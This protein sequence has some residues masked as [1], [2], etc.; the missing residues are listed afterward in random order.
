MSASAR[1]RLSRRRFLGYG[2]ATTAAVMLGAGL[3]DTAA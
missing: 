2:G 1:P 3:A